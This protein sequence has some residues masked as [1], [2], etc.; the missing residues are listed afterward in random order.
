MYNSWFIIKSLRGLGADTRYFASLRKWYPFFVW[1]S[2]NALAKRRDLKKTKYILQRAT[3]SYSD[4]EIVSKFCKVHIFQ[5]ASSEFSTLKVNSLK[6][7]SSDLVWMEID[8]QW[9]SSNNCAI[10]KTDKSRLIDCI[11]STS[12]EKLYPESSADRELS[13]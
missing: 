3:P 7:K 13:M 2:Q 10:L 8:W 12:S 4:C 5:D 6:V 11:M 1:D 9:R